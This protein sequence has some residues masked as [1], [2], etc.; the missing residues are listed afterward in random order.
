MLGL[1]ALSL[2]LSNDPPAQ[3]RAVE[4]VTSLVPGLDE[5]V[6]TQFT[7]TSAQQV[8]VGILG[9]LALL[10]AVSSFAVRVRTALGVIFRTGYRPCSPAGSPVP[11]SGW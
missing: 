3:Q 9:G 6:H 7:Q 11:G 10:W 2:V 5:V 4:S 1:A 8:G